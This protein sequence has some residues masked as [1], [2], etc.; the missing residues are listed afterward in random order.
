MTGCFNGS[1]PTAGGFGFNGTMLNLQGGSGG[2]PG[3]N[4]QD[5]PTGGG[6]G[7][8]NN[9]TLTDAGLAT[10]LYGGNGGRGARNDASR[11]DFETTNAQAYGGGGGGG[12]GAAHSEP[13][14]TFCNGA[15]GYVRIEW[16]TF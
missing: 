2:G 4:G 16:G 14:G 7:Y 9:G 15:G 3:D 13:Y 11:A 1:A 6:G 8:P 5:G 12:F 10:H